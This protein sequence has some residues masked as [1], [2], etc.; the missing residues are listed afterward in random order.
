MKDLMRKVYT[1]LNRKTA[2]LS[3]GVLIDM[4]FEFAESFL[5]SDGESRHGVMRIRAT[6][7]G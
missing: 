3:G 2:T 1:S 5:D 4:L 6:I 7:D